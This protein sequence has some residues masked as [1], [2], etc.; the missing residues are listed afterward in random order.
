MNL[1]I[2]LIPI[3]TQYLT[4]LNDSTIQYIATTN[5]TNAS[6]THIAKFAFSENITDTRLVVQNGELYL[7]GCQYGQPVITDAMLRNMDDFAICHN[8]LYVDWVPEF[9]ISD[10]SNTT[11]VKRSGYQYTYVC[12]DN[13]CRTY[14]LI[15]DD[16][17]QTLVTYFL[18][19]YTFALFVESVVATPKLY[20][21]DKVFDVKRSWKLL[22]SHEWM[23]T[24]TISLVEYVVMYQMVFGY[25]RSIVPSAHHLLYQHTR[26]VMYMFDSV[27]VL[28]TAVVYIM[29]FLHKRGMVV[30][31]LPLYQTIMNILLYNLTITMQAGWVGVDILE[32]VGCCIGIFGLFSN[33]WMIHAHKAT[34]SWLGL[35]I[36]NAVIFAFFASVFMISPLFVGTSLTMD[37]LDSWFVVCTIS[38]SVVNLGVAYAS[39]FFN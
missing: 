2:F 17:A 22:V 36:A 20:T 18:T 4:I 7:D 12:A 26:T 8:R 25:Q 39:G 14:D 10:K 24:N 32:L 30:V 29:L 23:I 15:Q 37:C 9:C 33:G 13:K 1:S 31:I 19:L 27:Y 3:I 6:A 28:L 38:L 21:P 16:N 5:C 11:F 35:S 34:K